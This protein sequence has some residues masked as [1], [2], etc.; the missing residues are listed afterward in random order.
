QGRHFFQLHNVFEDMYNTM[1]EDLDEIAERVL[2]ID[3]K[4]LA[5]MTKY[6][7]ETTLVEATA[8]DKEDEITAQLV[9]DYRQMITEIKEEGI[10][11]ADDLYDGPIIELLATLLSKLEKYIWMLHAYRAYE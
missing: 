3:G 7:K 5:T 1:A 2:M 4:P 10:P 11:L 9:E 8:D 6:M